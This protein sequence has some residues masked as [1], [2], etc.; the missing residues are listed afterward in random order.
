MAEDSSS[1]LAAKRYA[2]VTGGNKGIGFEI[3]KQLA[4]KGVVVIL[5]ARDQLRGLD[6]VQKL[7]ACGLSEHVVFHQLDVGNSDSVAEAADFVRTK[8]GKLDILVNN[9]A[10]SGVNF[11]SE[12]FIKATELVGGWPRGALVDW[13]EL[14]TQDYDMAKECLNINYYGTKRMVETFISLLQLSDS[15]RIVNISSNAGLLQ[16]IQNEWAKGIL[17]DAESLT[18]EKV[19]EV[20]AKFLQDFQG[21]L[22]E[23]N[24]W[25]TDISAYSLSKVAM[26]AYTRIVAKRYPSILA[27]AVHPGFVKTDITLNTGMLTTEEGAAGP[28]SVALLP[29]DAPSGLFYSIG[30]VSSF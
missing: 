7:N 10:V 25:P 8:F 12:A 26:N 28:I 6:A 14:A 5:T 24:G 18:E 23:S 29:G 20:L 22:L 11:N 19:E 2:V 3:C 9:A 4:S 16:R 21:D 17:T 13:S 27:N 15:P 30:E 1:F